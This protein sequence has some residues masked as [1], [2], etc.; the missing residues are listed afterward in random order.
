M[1][2]GIAVYCKLCFK[3]KA[4]HGRSIPIGAS[5]CT[6]ENCLDYDREPRPGCLWPGETADEFGF[7]SCDN[8]TEER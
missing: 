3:R 4:P 2:T 6:S 7:F 8:A 1:K 5:F